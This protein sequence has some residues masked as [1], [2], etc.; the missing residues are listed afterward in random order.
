MLTQESFTGKIDVSRQL[1]ANCFW[2]ATLIDLPADVELQTGLLSLL[3][4]WRPGGDNLY[5]A[6]EQ[7][8]Q[9]IA[10]AL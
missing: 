2:V 10:L 6:E 5:E 8:S 4:A 9:Y 3:K 7:E 1:L